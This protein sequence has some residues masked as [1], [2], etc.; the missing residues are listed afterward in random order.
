MP[1]DETIYEIDKKIKELEFLKNKL[2]ET[3]VA[4]EKIIDDYVKESDVLFNELKRIKEVQDNV[5]H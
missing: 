3:I 5:K 2:L 4:Y 1:I